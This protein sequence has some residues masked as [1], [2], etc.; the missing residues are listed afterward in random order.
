LLHKLLLTNRK[1]TMLLTSILQEI[2]TYA[3]K[4][5]DD[6]VDRFNNRYTVILLVIFM[7]LIAG[8]QY[9]GN[10]I[11]WFEINFFVF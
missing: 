2:K 5:D 6:I 7:T 11:V 1:T 9:Y 8:K 3:N 4:H 10:P